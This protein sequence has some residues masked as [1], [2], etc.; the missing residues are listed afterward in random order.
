MIPV[1]DELSSQPFPGSCL[2]SHAVEERSSAY[3]L[4][5]K[6]ALSD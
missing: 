2:L 3:G 4:C 5:V 6:I 1:S